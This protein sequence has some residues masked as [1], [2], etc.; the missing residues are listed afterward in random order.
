[1]AQSGNGAACPEPT[2]CNPGDGGCPITCLFPSDSNIYSI[3]D[4]NAVN[5]QVGGSVPLQCD[6]HNVMMV[7]LDPPL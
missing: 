5:T 7:I 4:I 1:M 2:A 3:Y 6:C